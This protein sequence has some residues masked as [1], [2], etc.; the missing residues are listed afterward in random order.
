M[1]SK[2]YALLTL[3][4]LFGLLFLATIVGK[5]VLFEDWF[6]LINDP[7]F[8]LLLIF[9]FL[10]TTFLVCKETLLF[11]DNKAKVYSLWS[12]LS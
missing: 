9:Y 8:L 5:R 4:S 10:I 3:T 6:L 2:F 11:L 7:S 12:K 1:E